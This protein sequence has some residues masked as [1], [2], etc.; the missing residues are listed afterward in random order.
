MVGYQQILGSADFPHVHYAGGQ[1]GIG[2]TLM[3][4]NEHLDDTKKAAILG[5]NAVRF[6]DLTV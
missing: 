4:N 3:R 2:F 6:Y 1:L 5:R